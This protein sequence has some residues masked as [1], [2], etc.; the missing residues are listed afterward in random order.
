MQVCAASRELR[1]FVN[2]VDQGVAFSDL[3]LDTPLYG[4]ASLY[5][6]DSQIVY[7]VRDS[8]YRHVCVFAHCTHACI[9]VLM[10]VC[11]VYLAHAN[12]FYTAHALS[13][14]FVAGFG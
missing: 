11:T 4:A 12:I 14:V 1:F 10:F 2:G 3:P 13:F 8:V 5:T 6:K 7:N 9:F